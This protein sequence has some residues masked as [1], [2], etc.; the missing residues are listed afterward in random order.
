MLN[1][2]TR[3]MIASTLMIL[4]APAYSGSAMQIYRCEQDD[5]ATD[6]QVDEIASAWLK[7]A[8]GMKG[9]AELEGYLRFPIAANTGE[10]DFAFVLVAPSFEAWGAFTDAYSGSPAEEIDEKFDEIADCTRSAMWESFKV[11]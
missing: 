11:E 7:A 4:A 3:W 5:S 1:T 6:E 8:R 10:H 9:G 2:A